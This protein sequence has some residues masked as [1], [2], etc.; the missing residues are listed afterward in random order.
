M[1]CGLAYI[2]TLMSQQVLSESE[3]QGRLTVADLCALTPL[4]WVHV[5]RTGIGRGP[6]L[7]A[8]EAR[9]RCGHHGDGQAWQDGR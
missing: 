2:N 1:E 4:L 7:V 8:T 6:R 3:W 9:Q 5:N